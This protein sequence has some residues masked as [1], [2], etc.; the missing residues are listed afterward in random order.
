MSFDTWLSEN[1]FTDIDDAQRSALE[2]LY[3]AANPPMMT[4]D[5]EDAPA[6]AAAV[7]NEIMAVTNKYGNPVM[8]GTGVTVAAH[9]IANG[10]TPQQAEVQAMR[11]QLRPPPSPLRAGTVPPLTAAMEAAI[12][13][14]A[15]FSAAAEK[16]YG[17]RVMEASRKFQSMSL[18]DVA[19][20]TLRAGGIAV[21]HERQ[22][23]IRAAFSSGSLSTM[24]G[25][26]NNK[27]LET[28]WR[29]QEPTWRAFAATRSAKDFKQQTSLRPTFANVLSPLPETG[30]IDHGSMSEEYFNWKIAS[31][32][33]MFTFDRQAVIND[34]L[35]SFSE[36]LPGL[37]RAAS[38]T[39][40][41]LVYSLILADDTNFTTGRGNKLVSSALSA[42]SLAAAVKATKLMK[43][44]SG[45]ALDLAL[46]TLVVPPSLEMTARALLESGEIARNTATD[47]QLP[48]G[49]TLKNAMTLAVESRLENGCTNPYTGTTY[50]GSATSWYAFA[51][52][53]DIP[54]IVGFL[55]GR[56]TPTVETFGMNA[57]P[58]RLAMSWRV[59]HD[60]GAAFGDYR[61]G[62]KAIS[63]AS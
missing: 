12:L 17:P 36:I 2:A 8:A 54:V 11:S 3:N 20:H 28:V 50:A 23:M 13:C 29:E 53:A 25:N 1:G 35:G 51:A 4:D 48:T 7:A 32:A 63:A 52:P 39:L 30:S 44:P 55:D 45:N 46:R 62:L 41:D 40:S 34:D 42:T 27:V 57:D 60:F 16:A 26:V 59:Y 10:W 14:K 5:L 18:M 37:V 21:P 58:N 22:E 61:A 43:D 6:S 15:G 56:E 19:A 31:F 49:N 47:S 33:K 24:L 9:A 38:R